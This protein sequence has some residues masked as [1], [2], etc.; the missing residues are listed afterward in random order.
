MKKTFTK[1]FLWAPLCLLFTALVIGDLA[2]QE[3]YTLNGR[4]T[5]DT[6][7]ALPGVAVLVQGTSS[8]TVTDINGAY[9]VNVTGDQVLVFSF[10]GY[11]TTQQPING[12]TQLDISMEVDIEE[13]EEIVVVGY[14]TQKRSHLTG[15][16]SKVNNENLD[17]IPLARV[18]DA[19]VG[20]I[21]GVMVS[22]T[23]PAAGEA[24]VL[25]VRGQGSI[26]YD[27]DPLIVLDGIAVGNDSDFLS[28]LDMND[29]ESV[30]VLK[31]ASS[32]AIYGSRGANGVIMI[33]TKQGKEGPTRFSYNGYVGFKSV[34]D[35]DLLPQLDDWYDFVRA[36]NGGE[37]TE[38]AQYIQELGTRTDWQDVMM[39]GGTI[40][41]HALS[42]RGGTEN[43][44]YTAALSYLNDEGVLLTDNFEKINFRLN[45]NTK[46][47]DKVE[48]GLNLNP[49]HTEQRRF[50]IGVHDAIRQ[51]PWLPL[52]LDENNFQYVNLDPTRP[53]YGD[54]EYL[55]S[56]AAIGGYAMER[57][58]DDYD[59]VNGQSVN[60]GGTD[61]S[62]TS[63]QNALAKVLER[64]QRRFQ[65]MLYANTFVKVNINDDLFFRQTFGGDFRYIRNTNWTGV[66]ASR[67]GPGDSESTRT[68]NLRMHAV[69][70]ST[71]NYSK[72]IG[73]HSVSAVA[74]FAYEHWQYEE[75]ELEAAGFDNDFIQTIPEANQNGGFSLEAEE[76]L[77]SYLARVN[78]AY[79]NKYLFSFSARR[80]GSSKFGLNTKFG[81]FPAASVGWNLTEESFLSGNKIVQDLK[82]RMSYGETGNNNGI[83]QYGHFG[84]ISPVGTGFGSTGFNADN[85]RNP[86]LGWEKLVEINPGIDASFL[87]GRLNFSVDYYKR[88]SK[89]LL[90][91]LP[92]PSV[93]GFTTALV[94]RGEVENEGVEIELSSMNYSSN[95]LT[96]TT[97]A[98]LSRNKNTL[99]DFAGASGLITT[100]DNKR[101]LEWIA[102]EGNPVS[103]FYG[104][105]MDD[106][107]QID[108]QFINNPLYPIGGQTQDVYVKDLDGNGVIDS[109]DRTI[110]GSP[111]P[112]VVWS[113][114]NNLKFKNFDLSFMFQG[115]HGAEVRNIIS[116]Y[117]FNEFA[118]AQDY[119][120]SFPDADLVRRRI[121]TDDDIQDA[122]YV[123][124]R[125][126]NIGYRI[127]ESF[128]SPAGIRSARVYVAAQN[129]LYIMADGYQGYNPEGIDRALDSP[130]TYGYQRGPAPIYRSF[131]VGVNIEF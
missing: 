1:R 117:V 20:Q 28:S 26:S 126:L 111:Y 53:N 59:L 64:D 18:D 21:A 27:S 45:V 74:G 77:V 43:T 17:Q 108:P 35:N 22:Q 23:N 107:R 76:I 9:T 93:T 114:I 109:N 40:T 25:R 49:S 89:D 70:E 87:S 120:G 12:K 62:A 7:E 42:A 54:A 30:E 73:N 97:T 55:F 5:D 112:D 131:S 24:P 101:A 47:N 115:S 129:L 50:P 95:N 78:Y 16:V 102:L 104:Y 91:D 86:D 99:T 83:G 81:F 3:A 8:G 88:T 41:S 69:S 44:K 119:T 127:P 67:N 80:D 94:N 37:L 125:N 96:W 52:Y 100:V 128:L 39:D 130:L 38:R 32:S 34:P 51:G 33:T 65:T 116:E 31:D 10:I 56:N 103:S 79:D 46:V 90:L 58:F 61:I 57:F 98:N 106:S 68:T 75:S 2:A 82:L 66:L 48:F 105:V 92:I 72:N 122:S 14:G 63:N 71:I 60:D 13:L 15:S 19:L 11:K 110:L 113:V 29:V 124:L 84:L 4:V 85:I 123:V 36:N 121:N 118:S 6:G